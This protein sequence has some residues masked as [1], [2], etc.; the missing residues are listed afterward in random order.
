MQQ[1]SLAPPL[2]P[3]DF[4]E[5]ISVTKLKHRA[6][7]KDAT[8]FPDRKQKAKA[9]RHTWP[10]SEDETPTHTPT[11][12]SSMTNKKDAKKKDTMVLISPAKPSLRRNNADYEATPSSS[13]GS[14]QEH[15]PPFL[16][17]KNETEKFLNELSELKT[18]VKNRSPLQSFFTRLFQF[19]LPDDA[20][21]L[22][23]CP[24][25]D[26]VSAYQQFP[27]SWC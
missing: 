8:S 6:R 1:L 20:S 16:T 12:N 10:S 25:N 11:K 18:L 13:Q 9:S 2:P 21:V 27:S 4:E 14:S 24:K 5:A 3:P 26:S 23:S 19:N 15:I 17:P 22:D 7:D